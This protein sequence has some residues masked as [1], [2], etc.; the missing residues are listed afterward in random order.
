MGKLMV[1]FNQIRDLPPNMVA[2][3]IVKRLIK[4]GAPIKI[5]DGK[6]TIMLGVT[7]PLTDEDVEVTEGSITRIDGI[8]HLDELGILFKWGKD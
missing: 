1:N 8:Y 7:H 3:W 4:E 2:F 5:R 6:D